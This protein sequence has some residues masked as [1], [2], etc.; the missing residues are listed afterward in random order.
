M[1]DKNEESTNVR[2]AIVIGT[3]RSQDMIPERIGHLDLSCAYG[4]AAGEGY[5]YVARK[6][7]GVFAIDASDPAEPVRVANMSDPNM[8]ARRLFL[9]GGRLYVAGF[10]GGLYIYDVSDPKNP[11]LLGKYSDSLKLNNLFVSGEIAYL[12]GGY[13][14]DSGLVI[15]DVSNPSKPS[16]RGIYRNKAQKDGGYQSVWVTGTTVYAGTNAGEF[17][18]IDASKPS[19]PVLLGKYFNSGTPGHQPWLWG[20]KVHGNKA[21]LAD[22]GAGLIILDVSDPKNP[23]ELGVFTGGTDGPNEYG[24]VVEEGIAYIAN[25]WGALT[26]ADVSNPGNIS[27]VSEF[28]PPATTYLDIAKLGELIFCANGGSP[29]GLDIIRIK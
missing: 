22:W 3:V 11:K 25:G 19:S 20:I 2:L 24:V 9:D 26:V 4:V 5:A 10:T 16:L 7:K 8:D 1:G 27:F 13:S 23:T 14:T 15:L 28:N 12:A 18:I 29:Q 6:T 21:Y 17:H